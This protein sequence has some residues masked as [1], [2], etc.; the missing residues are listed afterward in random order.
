[1]TVP[2][3]LYLPKTGGELDLALRLIV[4]WPL[5]SGIGDTPVGMRKKKDG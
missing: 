3:K 5:I 2:I 4:G 1:M